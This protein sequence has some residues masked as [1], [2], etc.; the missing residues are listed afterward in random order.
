MNAEVYF[1][2]NAHARLFGK[3][4]FSMAYSTNSSERSN[5]LEVSVLER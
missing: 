2:F 1:D 3:T 4:V 5:V